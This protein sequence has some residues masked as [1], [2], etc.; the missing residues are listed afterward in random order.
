MPCFDYEEVECS[1]CHR[2][3]IDE[4]CIIKEK[5]VC[6]SCIEKELNECDIEEK[7]LNKLEEYKQ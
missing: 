1:R 3:V 6:G 5:I 7:Y 2:K 4:Y